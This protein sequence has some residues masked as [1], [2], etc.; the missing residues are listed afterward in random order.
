M[1]KI[2]MDRKKI[3]SLII[4]KDKTKIYLNN[5]ANYRKI[6]RIHHRILET[7]A[8]AVTI[9]ENELH[10]IDLLNTMPDLVD[11]VEE[12]KTQVYK[13]FDNIVN[14][15]CFYKNI[16][17]AMLKRRLRYR[18]LADARAISWGIA[19][20]N[21]KKYKIFKV[22]FM[23]VIAEYFCLKRSDIYHGLKLIEN[24]IHEDYIQVKDKILKK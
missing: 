16:N 18:E 12:I 10:L 20:E 11:Q 23:D 6:Q 8:D 19:M 13:D 17:K 24:T 22:R 21:Q 1:E 5:P 15:V 14:K 3:H 4:S 2:K 7:S 9:F